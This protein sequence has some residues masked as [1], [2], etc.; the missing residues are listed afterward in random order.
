MDKLRFAHTHDCF[1]EWMTFRIWT[2]IRQNLVDTHHWS[3]KK[4]MFVLRH[5]DHVSRSVDDCTCNNTKTCF[6]ESA[7]WHLTNWLVD[8]IRWTSPGMY[9]DMNYGDSR[10]NTAL[11]CVIYICSETVYPVLFCRWGATWIWISP[12]SNIDNGA[13]SFVVLPSQPGLQTLCKDLPD[14]QR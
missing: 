10:G 2:A 14:C 12:C 6:L 5:W 7:C 13:E 9:T 8:H 4:S 3:L 1:C 11:L